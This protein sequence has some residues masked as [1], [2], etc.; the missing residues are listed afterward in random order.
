M[1]IGLTP[2]AHSPQ[3]SAGRH[4]DAARKGPHMAKPSDEGEIAARLA[5]A[6]AA[7]AAEERAKWAEA[8]QDEDHGETVP[9]VLRWMADQVKWP[10]SGYD[11]GPPIV[12]WA[13]RIEALSKGEEGSSS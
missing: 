13:E 1:G 4:R 12:A 10:W 6:H 2:H 8:M 11:P 7:G 3:T 9:D 5:A